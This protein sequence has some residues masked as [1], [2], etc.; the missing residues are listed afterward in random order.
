M[1][2]IGKSRMH[3]FFLI[4]FSLLLIQTTVTGQDAQAIQSQVLLKTVTSWNGAQLPEYPDGQPEITLLK[5]TIPPHAALPLHKHP[6]INAG[7]LLS[8]RLTVVT[9]QGDTLHMAAGDSI[10]EVVETW[11]NG[12]NESD[13]PAEII[14]FYAGIKGE[15]ITVKTG[16]DK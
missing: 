3:Q 12:R 14:V 11:H 6:V 4:L 8:G 16:N 9:Q 15:P 13:D 1:N 2:R 10:C 5:I 7:I